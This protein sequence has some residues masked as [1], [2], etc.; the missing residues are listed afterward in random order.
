MLR[1][2]CVC[3]L[4][5]EE[6]NINVQSSTKGSPVIYHA[7]KPHDAASVL[8]WL[9]KTIGPRTLA[10]RM[11]SFTQAILS[12]PKRQLDA[13]EYDYRVVPHSEEGERR[14]A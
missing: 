5:I 10:R 7:G 3:S 11:G 6:L 9:K 14:I 13:G 1:N 8:T 4:Q 12:S 2:S